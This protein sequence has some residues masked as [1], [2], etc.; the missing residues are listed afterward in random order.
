MPRES[1]ASSIPD[2]ARMILDRPLARAM[3]RFAMPS[4]Y[5]LGPRPRL[6]YTQSPIQRAAELRLKKAQVDAMA[7]RADA[8]AYV[9]GGEMIVAK[10]G[11]PNDP[12]F[13]MAEAA[14]LGEAAEIVFL[15]ALDGAGRF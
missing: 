9:I 12:L 8:G 4:P 5:D 6:G 7:A 15:G 14:A 13:T 3:T 1:G 11:E 2:C 10:V